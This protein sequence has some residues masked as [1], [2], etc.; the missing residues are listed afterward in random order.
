MV[1]IFQK[2]EE[3]FID[4]DEIIKVIKNCLFYQRDVRRITEIFKLNLNNFVKNSKLQKNTFLE[5]LKDNEEI[6]DIFHRNFTNTDDVDSFFDEEI[7]NICNNNLKKSKLTNFEDLNHCDN[8]NRKLENVME[9]I[10]K[11]IF[12]N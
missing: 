4:A 1:N 10:N 5:F 3:P 2:F 11:V 9:I 12:F 8:M 7:G 6:Q